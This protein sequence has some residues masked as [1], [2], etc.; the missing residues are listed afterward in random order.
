MDHEIDS[1]QPS[2]KK[3]AVWIRPVLTI[4]EAGSAEAA[5]NNRPEGPDTTS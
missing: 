1:V 3:R 4:I 5:L 2:M